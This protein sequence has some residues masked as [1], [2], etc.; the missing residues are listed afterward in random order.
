[1]KLNR[2]ILA[3]SA[4]IVALGAG[5][6]GI[7]YAVSGGSDENVTGPNADKAKTAALAAVPGGTVTEI[8]RQDGDGSGAYEV[9]VKR[10]DGSQVEVHVN[11]QFQVVGQA[12]DDDTGAESENESGESE[13]GESAS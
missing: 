8:E 3:V 6:A 13:S 2:K 10:P 1:M 5:G 12:S 7:A 9:E 11:S 4:V